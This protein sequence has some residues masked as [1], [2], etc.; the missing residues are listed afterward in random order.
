MGF[1]KDNGF[2]TFYNVRIPKENLLNRTGDVTHDGR[3]ITP[4]KVIL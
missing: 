1:L 3:Y 4:F 2:A